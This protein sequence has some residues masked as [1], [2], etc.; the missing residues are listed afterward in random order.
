MVER[1]T[2]DRLVA[3]GGRYAALFDLQSNDDG[4]AAQPA[5]VGA[6]E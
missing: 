6:A 1:G 3:M 4:A 5:I 2:H